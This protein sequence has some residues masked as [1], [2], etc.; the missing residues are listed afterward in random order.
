MCQELG[1]YD[2]ARTLLGQNLDRARALGNRSMEG[3]SLGA[4]ASLAS[5]EG[6]PRDAVSLLKDVLRIDSDLGMRYQS[7]I[8]LS[9]F[10]RALA[11]DGGADVDAARLLACAEAMLEEIG[12]TGPPYLRTIHEEALGAISTRLD[13]AALAEALAA[14]RT[15]TADEAVELALAAID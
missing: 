12:T 10:A 4:L 15:L 13:Q 2:Q 6:R 11:Y 3:Q 14:G 8:D 5:L 7:A 1:E 9:R